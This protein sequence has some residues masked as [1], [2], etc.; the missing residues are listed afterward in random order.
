M[1][2]YIKYLRFMQWT[3]M[4]STGSYH[5]ASKLAVYSHFLQLKAFVQIMN[6]GF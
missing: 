4:S 1:N 2:S 3:Q 6:M 5:H